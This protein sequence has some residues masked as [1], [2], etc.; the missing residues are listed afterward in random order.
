MC[1]FHIFSIHPKIKNSH[2]ANIFLWPSKILNNI[3]LTT[4]T[5]FISI[6]A[7]KLRT[8]WK[9]R[10]TCVRFNIWYPLDKMPLRTHNTFLLF[11][12]ARQ[13]KLSVYMYCASDFGAFYGLKSR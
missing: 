11:Q 1:E 8:P 4:Q 12:N 9:F 2:N 5:I 6:P 13:A 7:F 10:T 3:V